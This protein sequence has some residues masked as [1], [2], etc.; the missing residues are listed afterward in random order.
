[1]QAGDVTA[2]WANVDDLIKDYDYRPNTSIQDGVQKFVD[3]F[4]KYYKIED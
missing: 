3:W 2:T 4:K 1:M